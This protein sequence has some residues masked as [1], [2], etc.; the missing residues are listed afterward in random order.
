MNVLLLGK[1]GS[2]MHWTEDV[3]SDLS[4]AGHTVTVVPT[5]DPRLSKSLERA[6]LSRTIG[7][8]LAA[9]IVRRMRRLAPDLILAIGCL[10]EFPLTLFQQ[11]A[12]E[13][14][15]PPMVAWIGDTFIE[16]M[17]EVAGL[18]DVIAYTDTGMVDLHE[19]LGF[20]SASAFV[21]LG[22]TRAV[23]SASAPVRRIPSLAFVAA[24]T[25][26]RRALLAEVTEPVAI[27]GPGW[28]NAT[29]LGHH[30]RDARRIDEPELAAIYASH[31]GVLNIRHAVYVINGLNHRHFA[32]YIQGTPVITDA[33]PDI[34]HCFEAGTEMLTYQNAGDL[35][36]LLAAL[37]RNPAWAA[38]IGSA[39]QRRVLACHTYTHR[40]ATI[41]ALAGIRT[42]QTA[43]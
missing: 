26:N 10:D 12:Q 23:R 14:D 13:R 20:R 17:G 41:A 3:A 5:R 31:M 1:T 40:L 22:A 30:R 7:A 37:R 35:N 9:H 33:Q 8:P 43:R 39:G 19:N 24:P 28:Q 15:R 18:F 29:E 6:L 16:Q 36:E 2:I 25:P 4:L 21:P 34:P 38:A 11:I 32:P 27:F 42:K